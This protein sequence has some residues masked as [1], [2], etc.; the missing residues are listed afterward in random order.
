MKKFWVSFLACGVWCGVF[1]VQVFGEAAEY[2]I[3]VVM[4]YNENVAFGKE[5]KNGI[6]SVL[7]DQAE[8]RYISLDVMQNPEGTKNKAQAAYQEFQSFQPDGV[9]AMDDE[10][11]ILFVLPYL[12]DKVDIPI[13]FGAIRAEPDEYGYPTSH[14][15]GI[16]ARPFLREGFLFLQ[17]LVPSVKTVTFLLPNT[18]GAQA[19]AKLIEQQKETF[20]VQL[21][22]NIVVNTPEEAVAKVTEA[23]DQLD[24]LVI[25]P[26]FN[27]ET[28][29]QVVRAFGKPTLVDFRQPLEYGILCAV[30]VDGSEHGKTAANMLLQALQGV[31]VSELPVTVNKYG[32]RMIN[33]TAMQQLG[34]KPRRQALL[35]TELIRTVE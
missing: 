14:I 23:K 26:V 21:S 12:K 27:K 4:G 28:I 22:D 25:A 30:V 29:Q 34:I 10:T 9:I 3:L 35:G 1:G 18:P 7:G 15:S 32:K 31:P 17:Q 6:E 5:Y 20:S 8:I 13:M 16:V 33:A 19:V 24:A 2:K 11:Q